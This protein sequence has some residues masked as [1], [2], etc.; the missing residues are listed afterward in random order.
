MKFGQKVEAK[1][2]SEDEWEVAV[3][4]CAEAGHIAVG[5]QNGEAKLLMSGLVRTRIEAWRDRNREKT[6]LYNRLYQRQRRARRTAER[7]GITL[8]EAVYRQEQ[9]R[10]RRIANRDP[11][12]KQRQYWR[13]R[14]RAHREK[15]AES[16]GD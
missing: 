12:A 10:A 9:R 1:R 5:F 13:D 14:Q 16:N 3:F 6:R 2:H 11:N 7:H 15:K 4:L 8:E